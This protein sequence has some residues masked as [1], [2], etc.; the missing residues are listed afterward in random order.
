MT[1]TIVSCYYQL[2]TSKHSKDEYM[3]WITNFLVNIDTPIVMFSDGPEY[4][5]M[6]QIRTHAGLREK[7][8]PVRKPFSELA[9]STPGW[10]QIWTNQVE[11]SNHKH[12]HNQELFRIWA[13]KSFFV[14]E[15][16]QL[17]PFESDV[18]VWCDAGCWRDRRVAYHFG[19]GWPSPDSLTP[20]CLSVLAMT[21]LS[22]FFEKVTHPTIQT[23]DDVVLQIR[24]DNVLTV[25]GTI[26]AGDKAAWLKWTPTFQ[27]VLE[28][29]IKHDLFA[30]D[31]QSVITSTILWLSKTDPTS[32]PVI[33]R[34]PFGNGFVQKDG[35]WIGD[36]WFA[37]QIFLSQE[38]KNRF[39]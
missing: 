4:E 28:T 1:T 36:N 17:N 35:V 13:N 3:S 21:D 18:F 34:A 38:F 5:F 10:I 25:G 11:K 33:L 24:T 30:G 39:K 7:F 26:L 27:S 32:C 2:N 20:G 29:F 22:P 19:K 9:F 14:Q 12:L 37:L 6:C 15:A 31:D 8:F 23:L 16:I